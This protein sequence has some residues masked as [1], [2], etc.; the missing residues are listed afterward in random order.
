M[1]H[2]IR[3][4]VVVAASL[5]TGLVRAFNP[6]TDTQE[7]VTLSIDGVPKESQTEKPLAFTVRL[8]NSGTEPVQGTVDV[9][10]NDDWQMAGSN[11]FAVSVEPGK[12]WQAACSATARDR[13]LTAL[14]P[15]HA[16]F[17]FER[18]NTRIELHPIAVFGAVRPAAPTAAA[19]AGPETVLTQGAW[20][21]TRLTPHASA[22]ERNGRVTPLP[23][24]F[25]GS[26]A[27]SGATWFCSGVDFGGIFRRCLS[28]HPPWKGGHGTL[29]SD[30]RLKLP[31]ET[32]ILLRVHTA[33]REVRPGER[34]SDGVEFKV[35]VLATD[36]TE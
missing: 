3:L 29:W 10:L 31:A 18:N 7:R 2:R 4:I 11:T 33:V 27:E 20:G 15:I 21:L 17:T 9:R 19:V 6:P 28:I 23:Y 22:W 14:Y 24:G 5:V 8:K 35:R 32:P 12:T 13:V 36:Q 34:G 25:D 16:R 30:Y 26:E 1:R